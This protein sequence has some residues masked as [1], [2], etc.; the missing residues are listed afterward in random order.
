MGG[1][2]IAPLGHVIHSQVG[3]GIDEAR[4]D[5]VARQ[6]PDSG[7]RGSLHI[8]THLLDEPVADHDGGVVHGLS[9][10][11]DHP[12]A[13]QCMEACAV[14]PD[15]R[16]RFGSGRLLGSRTAREQ[17]RKAHHREDCFHYVLQKRKIKPPAL[18]A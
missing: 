4:I 11:C 12:R 3:V 14:V 16:H 6:V 18:R 2:H 17:E 7:P 13:H 9:R 15:A 8:S 5:R 1:A 10:S